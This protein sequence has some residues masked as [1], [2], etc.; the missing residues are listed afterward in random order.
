MHRNAHRFYLRDLTVAIEVRQ[1]SVKVAAHDP[2][3]ANPSYPAAAT[4]SHLARNGPQPPTY[5]VNTRGLPG[6]FAPTYQESALGNSVAS[7]TSDTC[8]IQADWAAA[9]GSI[10]V[11]PC[12]R[13]QTIQSRTHSTCCSMDSTTLEN[14]AGEPGPVIMNIFGNPAAA[15]PR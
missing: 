6:M 13:S 12:D 4:A 3:S 7:A 9:V 2:P 8:S 15:T 10:V 11:R 1:D 5:E 14:T